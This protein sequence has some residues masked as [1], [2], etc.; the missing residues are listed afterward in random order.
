MPRKISTDLVISQTVTSIP[1]LSE[2]TREQFEVEV[3]EQR[4]RRDLEDGVDGHEH[5]C[6]LAVA[7][8]QV[9]PDEHHGD[10]PGKADDDQP[11]AVVGKVG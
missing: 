5:R 6:Q 2:P 7:A 4:V 3:A 9:V 1:V 8:G 11:R 10:A